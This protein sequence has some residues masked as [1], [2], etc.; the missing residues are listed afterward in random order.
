M[1]LYNSVNSSD[2]NIKLVNELGKFKDFN[3]PVAIGISRKGFIGSITNEEIPI[4]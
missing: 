2:E 3:V 1:A 4:M